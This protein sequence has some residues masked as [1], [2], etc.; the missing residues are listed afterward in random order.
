MNFKKLEQKL[1]LSNLLPNYKVNKWVFRTALLC[2]V[3]F[4]FVAYAI[5]GFPDLSKVYVYASCD[6]DSFGACENPFYSLCNQEVVGSDP[7]QDLCL[8]LNVSD[9]QDQFLLVG[10]SVGEK[11]PVLLTWAFDVW[12]LL[13]FGA[14]LFNHFVYNKNYFKDRRDKE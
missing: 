13:F 6:Y 1:K 14:F 4:F 8:Q 9:Y 12:L 10:Q 5:A 11:P 7:W 3:A 2:M